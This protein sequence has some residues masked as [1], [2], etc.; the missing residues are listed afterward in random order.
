M[1]YLTGPQNEFELPIRVANNERV[2]PWVRVVVNVREVLDEWLHVAR[3]GSSHVWFM[4]YLLYTQAGCILI[5]GTS[6]TCRIPRNGVLHM[7]LMSSLESLTPTSTISS[8]CTRICRFSEWV[9]SKAIYKQCGV[10]TRN[11]VVTP[12]PVV[13]MCLGF[14]GGVTGCILFTDRCAALH[15][16]SLLTRGDIEVKLLRNAWIITSCDLCTP[17]P[18]TQRV[19]TWWVTHVLT[20]VLGI[21]LLPAPARDPHLSAYT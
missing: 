10:C 14:H 5:R 11:M 19:R 17:H 12:V 3:L 20:G 21:F 16:V 4:G 18:C 8:I 15:R 6:S 9:F 1:S 7:Q 13:C 2:L